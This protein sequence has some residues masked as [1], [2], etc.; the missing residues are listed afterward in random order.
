MTLLPDLLPFSPTLHRQYHP[1][2]GSTR[3]G[4]QARVP[5]RSEECWPHWQFD[6]VAAVPPGFPEAMLPKLMRE[7]ALATYGRLRE[8]GSQ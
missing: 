5:C 4:L 3:W 7:N 1:H 8:E 6:G 2:I